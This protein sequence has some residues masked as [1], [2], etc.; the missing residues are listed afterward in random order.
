[1]GPRSRSTSSSR[2]RSR[3]SL[4][5]SRSPRRSRSRSRRRPRGRSHSRDRARPRNDGPDRG[6]MGGG[7]VLMNWSCDRCG[8]RNMAQRPNCV[9]CKTPAPGLQGGGPPRSRGAPPPREARR[10]PGMDS[11]LSCP[12]CGEPINRDNF[13]SHYEQELRRLLLEQ[14]GPQY[15]P[16][17]MRIAAQLEAQ[18][19]E[20]PWLEGVQGKGGA[21]GKGAAGKGVSGK[22]AAGKGADRAW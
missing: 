8:T 10:P 20:V 5:R 13:A 18:R 6:R 15:E 7:A 1:M 2:S 17:V 11:L 14:F 19:A 22:G 9:Q 16:H 4:S 3:S 12:V 21:G